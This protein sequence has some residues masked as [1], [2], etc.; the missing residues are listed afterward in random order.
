MNNTE[1]QLLKTLDDKLWK[2]ADKLR[3]HLNAA[4]YKHVVP[5]LINTFFD[6]SF[7]KPVFEDETLSL[8]SQPGRDQTKPWGLGYEL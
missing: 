4:N 8:H 1:Q 2:A 7:T 3:T 5:G 6:T